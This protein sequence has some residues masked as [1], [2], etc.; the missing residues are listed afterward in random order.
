MY[1]KRECV[2]VRER[3]R[4]DVVGEWTRG[5]FAKYWK[6]FACVG[7]DRIFLFCIH[8]NW[9]FLGVEEGGDSFWRGG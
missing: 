4:E 7:R 2:V 8:I 5:A 1:E 6:A 9:S 3:E